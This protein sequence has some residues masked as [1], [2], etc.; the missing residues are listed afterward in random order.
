MTDLASAAALMDTDPELSQRMLNV[1]ITSWPHLKSQRRVEI[2]D[3]AL[4]PEVR[5]IAAADAER[6]E[7][8]ELVQTLSP[9]QQAEFMSFLRRWTSGQ[10]FAEACMA[11]GPGWDQI[12]TDTVEEFNPR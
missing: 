10:P 5:A 7:F 9:E 4:T 8:V 11:L 2:I 6:R 1:V 3:L 12:V